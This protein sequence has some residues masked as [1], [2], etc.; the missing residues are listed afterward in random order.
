MINERRKLRVLLTTDTIGGIW[1]YCLEL[2][3]AAAE[4]NCEFLLAAMGPPPT[5]SQR[6][7][8]DAL[9]NVRM[10]SGDYRLEWMDDPWEDV[11]AAGE[12]LLSLCRR[13]SGFH[14][15]VV[16]LNH[17]SFA[18]LPWRVVAQAG[19]EVPVLVV[20]HSCI[21][22]WWHAVHGTEAPQRYDEYRSRVRAG[23][24]AADMVVAPTRA[25][26]D[27]LVQLYGVLPDV[28]VMHNGR[29]AR[30]GLSPR[31][32]DPVVLAAGRLWDEAKNIQALDAA[33]PTLP[34]P[35]LVAGDLQ[36]PDGG[37]RR[38]HNLVVLGQLNHQQMADAYSRA[39]I[40]AHPVRYEPFGV[41]PL[42]AAI[43]GCALVLGDI[44]TLRE[45]W[46]GA[47]SFVDPHDPETLRLALDELITRPARRARAAA[48]AWQRAA[49]YSAER[50]GAGYA[51]LYHELCESAAAR[52]GPPR[53]AAQY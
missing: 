37:V 48:A 23:L 29:S 42:E 15:D 52:P 35:C 16:H 36:H 41:A 53:A 9:P 10:V 51:T 17:Y 13:S 49:I 38:P 33:A 7:M 43:A 46:D 19:G 6:R 21:C 30:A 45:L 27:E 31:P 47:A 8:V 44:P 4:H 39:A 3:A 2:M 50:F 26:L 32:K 28:R 25:M 24:A 14:P 20:A 40:F 5:S 18:S 11:D 34:W 22:S 12:W 1:T